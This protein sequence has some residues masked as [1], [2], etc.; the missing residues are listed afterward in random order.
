[1][2]RS[3]STGTPTKSTPVWLGDYG[4]REHILPGGVKL[5][6][7]I[8]AADA[9]GK[10]FVPSGTVVGRTIAERDASAPFELAAVGDNEV[11]I[12]VFDVDDV[13]NINDA[14]VARPGTLVKE[15]F[16]PGFAG[17]VAGV[18]ALVRGAYQCVRGAE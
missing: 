1:M 15:N 17:L 6:A 12:V 7:T 4:N 2:S 18:Q 10:R 16:L 11:F 13:A 3:M 5:S 8:V 9:Y 14:E